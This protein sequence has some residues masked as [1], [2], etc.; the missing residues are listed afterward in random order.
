L[1]GLD[2][3][4]MVDNKASEIDRVVRA[5]TLAAG[6]II[7]R[8]SING[9]ASDRIPEVALTLEEAQVVIEAVR[10]AIVYLTVQNFELADE[11]GEARER[12]ATLGVTSDPPALRAAATKMKRHE[13]RICRALARFVVG[14]ILHSVYG[15]AAWYDDFETAVEDVISRAS[16]SAGHERRAVDSATAARVEAMAVELSNHSSFNHVGCHSRSAWYWQRLYFRMMIPTHVLTLRAEPRTSSG[17]HNRGSRDRRHD[18]TSMI[19]SIGADVQHRKVIQRARFSMISVSPRLGRRMQAL[20]R[21]TKS[22]LLI[23]RAFTDDLPGLPLPNTGLSALGPQR[24]FHSKSNSWKATNSVNPD[25][26]SRDVTET[27]WRR[28]SA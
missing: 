12:L 7:V 13:G 25:L 24:P 6:A 26:R 23:R 19:I 1:N 10:P 21:T 16:E 27:R 17:L 2:A 8:A 5:A 28:D 18:A 4:P 14:S 15:S 20:S 11:L 9:G 3:A 22:G